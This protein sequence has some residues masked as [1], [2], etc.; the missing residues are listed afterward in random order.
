MITKRIV[1][2][3]PPDLVDQPIACH[4]VK[5]YNLEFNILKAS[6][7]PREEG[8]LVLELKGSNKNYKTGVDYLKKLGLNIQPLEKDVIRNEDKCTHCG[9][10]VGVCPTDALKV[11]QK[12]RRVEFDN[13]KCLAC[14]LCITACPTWAMELHF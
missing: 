11:N 10:C 3:F 13:T 7:T 9:L 8:V 6:V 4:L 1:V 5:D 2:R 12:N 14:E